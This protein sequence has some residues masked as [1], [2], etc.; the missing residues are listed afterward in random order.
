[1]PKPLA[2]SAPTT[3][4]ASKPANTRDRDRV[5]P[6]DALCSFHR[7]PRQCACCGECGRHLGPCLVLEG[8]LQLQG[9]FA[10]PAGSPLDHEPSMVTLIVDANGIGRCALCSPK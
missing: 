6:D 5:Q 7:S 3:P 10:P 9:L 4:A 8:Q 1:M 2:H